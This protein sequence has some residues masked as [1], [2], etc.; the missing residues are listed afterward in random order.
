M[1]PKFSTEIYLDWRNHEIEEPVTIAV[2]SWIGLNERIYRKVKKAFKKQAV[3]SETAGFMEVWGSA[4]LQIHRP[5]FFF[6]M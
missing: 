1:F 4:L 5:L 6:G 3:S 2:S